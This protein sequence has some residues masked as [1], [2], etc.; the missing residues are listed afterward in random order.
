MQLKELREGQRFEFA[1]KTTPVITVADINEVP[2]VGV[3]TYKGV[4]TNTCPLL[5]HDKM[6]YIFSAAPGTYLREVSIIL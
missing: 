5:L 2:P 4:G 3:F 1:D 6:S